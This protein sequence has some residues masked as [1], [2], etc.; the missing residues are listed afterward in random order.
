MSFNAEVAVRC[1]SHALGDLANIYPAGAPATTRVAVD[2]G[3]G[4]RVASP[5]RPGSN[6]PKA[7]KN[8]GPLGDR[9]YQ[10]A[11]LATNGKTKW[12]PVGSDLRADLT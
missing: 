8:D 11:T 10:R 3:D 12:W 6:V 4:G 2:A 5:R 7:L 1:R 9:I